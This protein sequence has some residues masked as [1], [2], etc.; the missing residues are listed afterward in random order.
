M[1]NKPIIG[2]IGLGEMGKPM[3]TNLIR[4]GFTLAIFDIRKE[5]LDQMIKEGALMKPSAFDV[6]KSA[7]VIITMLPN[8]ASVK[9]VFFEGLIQALD[10]HHTIIEMS[11]IDPQTTLEL[12]E[13]VI[14]KGARFIDAPIGGTPDMAERRDA[15]VLASGDKK[16]VD[17]CA[18]VIGAMTKKMSYVG[19]VGNGKTLKLVTNMLIGINKLAVTEAICFALKQ[20][21]DP[22]VIIEAIKESNG[23]SVVF[24]RY[25]AAV[26]DQDENIAK[27]HSW[28]LK[29]LGLLLDLSRQSTT[30][31]FLGALSMQ[32]TQAAS[33]SSEG[34][35]TFESIVNFYKN[36]MKVP[37]SQDR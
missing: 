32:I 29:D 30:P 28:Q 6:A 35:E 17:D 3:A 9:E 37:P 8:S 18:E 13:I 4:A 22:G 2:F 7:D 36:V 20:G 26:I 24:E 5:R 14:S 15:G 23:N 19:K 10:S 11:T 27:K 16:S 25:G 1:T 33:N 34:D 31:L 21:I 12:S